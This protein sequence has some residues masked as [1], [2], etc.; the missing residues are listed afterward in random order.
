MAVARLERK[1]TANGNGCG[2]LIITRV[3]KERKKKEEEESCWDDDSQFQPARNGK[4]KCRFVQIIDRIIF[5]LSFVF[6]RP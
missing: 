4:R 2:S 3:M 6:G 5:F 1:D